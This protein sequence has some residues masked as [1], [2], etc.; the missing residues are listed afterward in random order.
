MG[1]EDEAKVINE[2][3]PNIPKISVDYGIMEHADNVL[4][5]KGDFG[6]ND[7]GSFDTLPMVIPADEEGNVCHDEHMLLDSKGCICYSKNKL[8]ATIGV[9]NLVVIETPDTVLVCPRERM[10]EVSKIVERLEAE[11]REEYL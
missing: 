5:L 7:V 2:V 9:E 1:T 3:Y 10:Q 11:G 8:I 4:M 6:W